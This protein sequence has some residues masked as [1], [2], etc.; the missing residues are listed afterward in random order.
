M[1]IISF[2]RPS[3]VILIS[4]SHSP[5]APA[6]C[7]KGRS[8]VSPSPAVDT[9]HTELNPFP[10]ISPL[11]RISYDS[12]PPPHTTPLSLLR[13]MSF[14]RCHRSSFTLLLPPTL[15]HDQLQAR[16]NQYFPDLEK[17]KKRTLSESAFR[18]LSEGKW[19]WSSS[20]RWKLGVLYT[21]TSLDLFSLYLPSLRWWP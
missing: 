2:L 3:L 18:P 9:D 8:K 16:I 6:S 17:K 4:E 14:S 19:K 5:S 12:N 20:E 1:S 21:T 15:I 10:S 11:Q 7:H 13:V